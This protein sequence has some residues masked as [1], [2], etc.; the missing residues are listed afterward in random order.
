MLQLVIHQPSPAA[1][2]TN[3]TLSMSIWR[4]I[5]AWPA[6]SANFVENSRHRP[7]VRSSMRLAT[8]AQAISST[9]DAPTHNDP[10][11]RGASAPLTNCEYVIAVGTRPRFVA[12]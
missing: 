9:N 6:P 4:I 7:T 10:Q 11:V 1:R 5:R 2:L 12:G 3:V 8:L